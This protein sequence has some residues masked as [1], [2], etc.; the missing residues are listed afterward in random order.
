M[1]SGSS[2]W[3]GVA[4]DRIQGRGFDACREFLAAVFEPVGV[5]LLFP[6]G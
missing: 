5:G 1:A 6:V 2:S 4:A 3:I